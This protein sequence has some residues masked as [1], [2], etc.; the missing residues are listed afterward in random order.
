MW[1]DGVPNLLIGL[2]EGLEG[3]LVV[4]IL[5]AALRRGDNRSSTGPIWLGVLAAVTLSVSFGAVL[6]F[7]RSE[8]SSS[9]QE[10]FGGLL[11]VIAVGLVT[12]MIFWMRRTARGL[13]GELT[14]KATAAAG[15]GVTALVLTAFLAVAREGLETALFLWT[16]A[17]AAGEST[18]PLLGAALGIALAVLLCWLLYRRAIRLNLGVFF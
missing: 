1:A 11:S 5:L 7:S 9:T 6:T 13:S 12:A 17:Q 2:R 14:A 4:S 18:V 15:I 16:A 8:L 3:G 10:L